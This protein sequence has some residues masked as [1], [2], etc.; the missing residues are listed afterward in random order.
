MNYIYYSGLSEGLECRHYKKKLDVL[1]SQ[2]LHKLHVSWH[3]NEANKYTPS[4]MAD[5]LHD[6]LY[7]WK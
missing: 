6:Y 7:S 1:Q 2:L 5:D 4:N 3:N